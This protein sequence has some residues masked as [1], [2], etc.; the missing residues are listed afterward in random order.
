MLNKRQRVK[1]IVEQVLD[2][3]LG[4]FLYQRNKIFVKHALV[5]EQVEVQITKK[6]KEGY[7]GELVRVVKSSSIRSKVKCPFYTKCGGCSYLHMLYPFELKAKTE[8]VK[9]M[10]QKERMKLKVHNCV[11]MK[12]PEA[13]R[14]KLVLSFGVHPRNGLVA[15]FYEQGSH[16]IIHVDYCMMHNKQANEVIKKVKE[17][18]RKCRI[19]VF[20][21]QNQTGFLR[22]MVIRQGFSTKEMMLTF[23]CSKKEFRGK[24]NFLQAILR[25]FPEVTTIVQNINTRNTSIVLGDEEIILYG[26]GNIQDTLCDLRFQ[27]SAT[28]FY[29]INAEQ[30]EKL[31]N[32]ALTLA[33]ISCED[34]VV[35]TYCGIGTISLLVAKQAKHVYGVEINPVAIQNANINKH[36][37]KISNVNFI[38]EDAPT[39]MQ[40]LA[41]ENR[42]IDV[43]I[44]DPTRDGSNEDFLQAVQQL[45]PKKIVYI[46][47][48]PETQLRDMKFLRSNYTCEEIFL[49][50][51]FPRTTHVETVVL[52]SKVSK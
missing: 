30:C 2:N 11:G 26:K 43:L 10:V 32:K 31:Y 38:C 5:N 8:V 20:D 24:K 35:D 39:Y 15:G 14:N 22:H 21:E 28:S 45:K 23:V 16:H 48:N 34:V 40:Q 13:Y 52:M 41:N 7:L 27:M 6:L 47:C 12:E 37:N 3:G 25:Q 42:R 9:A 29:Q 51:M 1:G 46:S 17:I 36:L 19:E 4:M 33:K 49:F 50:D 44:M 18:L